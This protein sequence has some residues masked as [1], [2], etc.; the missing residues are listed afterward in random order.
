MPAP[1]PRRDALLKY[2]KHGFP[3]GNDFVASDSATYEY[4]K[5]KEAVYAL[6]D[7]G[8]EL[9]KILTYHMFSPLSRTRIAEEVGYDPSTIK[10]KLDLAADNV[11]QRLAHGNLPPED[12]F[13]IR[14]PLT[15]EVRNSP[16]PVTFQSVKDIRRDPEE[17]YRED[18][19][20]MARAKEAASK[21]PPT[22]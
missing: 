8:P 16:F 12:L 11:M 14:D 3:H 2:L 21:Q 20:A 4:T 15:G 7:N 6:K 18:L 19:A 9:L 10:R 13:S 1:N 17:I 22:S 5:V